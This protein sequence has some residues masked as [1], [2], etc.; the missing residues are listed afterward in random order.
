[1]GRPEGKH[2]IGQSRSRGQFAPIKRKGNWIVKVVKSRHGR[3]VGRVSGRVAI[4]AKV[5][6]RPG[7]HTV[8]RSNKRNPHAPFSE[9]GM[10]RVVESEPA[11]VR[12][13]SALHL[14]RAV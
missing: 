9:P 10:L 1:M 12:M 5:L 6:D 11:D 13:L 4:A 8:S 3:L 7:E 2:H 14:H